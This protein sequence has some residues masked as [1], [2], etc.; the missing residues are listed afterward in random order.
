MILEINDISVCYGQ[1]VAI[2]DISVAVP[3]SGLVALI[4]PNGAGKSTI[5]RTVSGLKKPTSGSIIFKGR[6]I[7]SMKPSKIALLGIAHCPEGRRPFPLMTVGENLFV[8][9]YKLSKSERSSQIEQVFRFFPILRE[10]KK[11]LAMTLSGGELQMLVIARSLMMKPSLYMLD[12]PS[13]GLAPL[14]IEEIGKII[15]NMKTSGLP[16]LLAEQNLDIVRDLSD[17][18]YVINHGLVC[19]SG[20]IEEILSREDLARTYM[21]M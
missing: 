7:S 1:S 21:G 14:L 4:G 17:K 15:A 3:E 20:T 6:L 12:E 9:G 11:Q 19:F 10:R 8:G 5:L 18:V 16:I 13:L 2:T